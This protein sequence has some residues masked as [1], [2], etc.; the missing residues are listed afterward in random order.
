MIIIL[1]R[2]GEKK[3]R[4]RSHRKYYRNVDH[5]WF[6]WFPV[7]VGRTANHKSIRMWL[8]F[9]CRRLENS[10]YVYNPLL[11]RNLPRIYG[12]DIDKLGF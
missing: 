4:I 9:V 3:K 6:A 12:S 2:S 1:G 7:V 10:G 11:G 5:R 8:S